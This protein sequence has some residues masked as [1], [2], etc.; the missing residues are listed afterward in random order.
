MTGYYVQDEAISGQAEI[1]FGNEFGELEVEGMLATITEIGIA[2]VW[3][4]G[5]GGTIN[6]GF[7]LIHDDIL[8]F[9][10]CDHIMYAVFTRNG[11]EKW[12]FKTNDIILSRPCIKDGTMFFGSFDGNFY[13]LDSETGAEK[14]RYSTSSRINSAPKIFDN[15][16]IVFGTE[17][18][19]LYAVSVNGE[20]LWKFSTNGPIVEGANVEDGTIVFCSWDKNVYALDFNGNLI[21]KFSTNREIN[22]EPAI[23]EGVVFIGGTDKIVYALQ[24]E[25]GKELWRYRNDTAI[26]SITM[27]DRMVLVSS[28]N[29]KLVAID[30][31]GLLLWNYNMDGYPVHPP[32]MSNGVLYVGSTD[33]SLHA[34]DNQGNRLW[35]FPTKSFVVCTPLIHNDRVFFGSFDCNVYC[36]DLDGN[37]I[38]KFHT[39]RSEISKLDMD[40]YERLSTHKKFIISSPTV[41]TDDESYK[42]KTH[43]QEPGEMGHYTVETG[44]TT[45][46]SKYQKGTGKYAK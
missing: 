21:W 41:S 7:G 35:K 28:Y 1:A 18:G 24:L 31:D 8:Y 32:G 20:L 3:V 2:P 9:G 37:L 14:W 43:H 39:S 19:N 15:D 25:T 46:M 27:L 11:Q 5:T 45:N 13:A 36:T 22:V 26:R 4:I 30:P 10:S 17:E 29:N 40:K 34:L 44:Y 6:T 42:T 38:W 12:R 23:S 33:Y 16:K